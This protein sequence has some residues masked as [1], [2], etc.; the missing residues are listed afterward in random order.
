MSA[1]AS[2]PVPSEDKIEASNTTT[3]PIEA[4]AAS[5]ETPSS[6]TNEEKKQ[7]PLSQKLANTLAAAHKQYALKKYEDASELYAQAAEIQDSINGDQNPLNADI[8][9][10]YGRSLFQTALSK[11]DILGS[12]VGGASEEKSA[13]KEKDTISKPSSSKDAQAPAKKG[14][15]SFQGDE[16]FDQSDEEEEGEDAEEGEEEEED[17]FS[18]AF[19]I[20]DL[21]KTLY[22]QRLETPNDKS[23]ERQIKERLAEVYDLL[24]EVSL[25]GEAFSQAVVDLTASL[26]LREKLYPLDSTLI[27]EGHYKL[28][29]ALEFAAVEKTEEDD[30]EEREHDDAPKIDPKE[31]RELSAKHMELAIASCRKRIE[32][33]EAKIKEAEDQEKAEKSLSE[34]KDLVKELEQRLQ[35]LTMPP[36]KIA[37]EQQEDRQTA[38]N[39]VLA[40]MLGGDPAAAKKML[41]QAISGANDIGGVV[42]KKEKKL[43]PIAESS[44]SSSAVNGNAKKRKAEED[45]ETAKEPTP[46]PTDMS[47]KKARVTSED[48]EAAATI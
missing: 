15:F 38:V 44:S 24:G 39:S 19:G 7:S 12:G 36:E 28:S 45:E 33:E 48:D 25:E 9:Y 22:Q 4:S 13:K 14:V 1:E 46:G 6:T 18:L 23:V 29:L 31:G 43:E 3:E 37:K 47:T 5:E 10:F 21:S 41:E 42:R 2:L 26:D 8:L 32:G 11:S 34:A 27:A 20:L 16:N 40:S 35:D 30:D 17:D